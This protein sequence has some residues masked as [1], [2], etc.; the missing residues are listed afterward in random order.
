MHQGP[1]ETTQIHSACA[2]GRDADHV[3]S[4]SPECPGPYPQASGSKEFEPRA[5][6]SPQAWQA[7]F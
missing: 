6:F 5:P 4:H 2:P 7:L 1:D 3:L